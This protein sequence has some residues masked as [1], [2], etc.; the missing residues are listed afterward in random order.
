M[1]DFIRPGDLVPG[2]HWNVLR[3]DGRAGVAQW[4]A[5]IGQPLWAAV[6]YSLPVLLGTL[7]GVASCC[8]WGGRVSDDGPG[9]V[10][11]PAPRSEADYLPC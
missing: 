6:G 11:D 3:R 9:I 2:R 5:V 8:Y 1:Q 4:V 10:Y 7:L